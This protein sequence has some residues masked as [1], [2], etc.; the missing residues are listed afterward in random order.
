MA[1]K[2]LGALLAPLLLCSA[3][4]TAS[5]RGVD[6]YDA[7]C[8]GAKKGLETAGTILPPLLA[9]FPVIYLLRSSGLSVT[10]IAGRVGY[11]SLS[12]YNRHF[13][14]AMGCTPMIWRKTA[15]DSPRP[16]LLTF[17]GWTEAEAVPRELGD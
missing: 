16:S 8:T 4:L 12:S 6:V 9:L 11:N 10:E 2:D 1:L 7:L 13:A 17:T 5:L 14:Q 3:L 15:G